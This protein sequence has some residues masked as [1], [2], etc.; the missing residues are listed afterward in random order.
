[1]KPLSVTTP[2]VLGPARVQVQFDRSAWASSSALGTTADAHSVPADRAIAGGNAAV[3]KPSEVAPATA[4]AIARLLPEHLDQGA[5]SVVSARGPRRLRS[6]NSH[7]THL[8]H[9]R[10]AVAKVVMT[11]AAKNRRPWC[12]NSAARAQPSFIV[13]RP[14]GRGAAHRPGPLE[15]RR[16]DLHRADYVLVFQGHCQAVPRT[17]EGSDP[18][19]LRRRP[20]K[21]RTT[22]GSSTRATST[23]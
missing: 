11:A 16:T 8:L 20:Q 9:R 13:G 21:S 4:D 10:T 15:Q 17:P 2:P 3:V 7:G 5:F 12:S 19:L 22:A 1:M 18:S 14:A 6:W 23:G